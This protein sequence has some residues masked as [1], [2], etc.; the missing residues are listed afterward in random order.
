MKKMILFTVVSIFFACE[1]KQKKV[2]SISAT[3]TIVSKE[4]QKQIPENKIDDL[5]KKKY[6]SI[7]E[8]YKRDSLKLIDFTKKTLDT[9]KADKIY[10]KVNFECKKQGYEPQICINDEYKML[11]TY[12]FLDPSNEEQDPIT[13]ILI[14]HND[15]SFNFLLKESFDDFGSDF[16]LFEMDEQ[17]IIVAD[18]FLGTSAGGHYY[19]VYLINKREAIFIGG[20]AGIFNEEDGVQNVLNIFE[21]ENK[22]CLLIST[23]SHENIILKFDKPH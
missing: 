8:I 22:I 16:F 9:L 20:E 19:Y 7:E 15:K 12:E 23:S 2:L 11:V 3:D 1:Q 10:K 14:K 18:E 13:K 17:K 5:N 4:E 6:F 21:K